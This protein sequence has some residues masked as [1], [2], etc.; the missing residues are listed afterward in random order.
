MKFIKITV[1]IL[2]IISLSGF[3]LT[4]A[5]TS[6]E[7]QKIV[8]EAENL[9]KK[10]LY[11]DAISRLEK[12]IKK[13][14]SCSQAYYLNGKAYHALRNYDVAIKNYKK[15]LE[16]Q[17]GW[18]EACYNI[19]SCY[20]DMG[21]PEQ[22]IKWI[23]QAKGI[24]YGKKE[25]E[26]YKKALEKLINISSGDVKKSYEK[27]LAAGHPPSTPQPSPV[28]KVT[29]KP[30]P[31]PAKPDDMIFIDSGKFTMGS[32]EKDIQSAVN[33]S[34][35]AGW[36]EVER[37]WFTDELPAHEVYVK[38]FYIDKYE[39]TNEKFKKF[40][41][42]TGYKTDAERE[43][44]SVLWEGADWKKVSDAD[45]AHPLGAGSSVKGK[46]DHPVVHVTWNDAKAYATWARMRLPSEAEWEY[47]CSGTDKKIF[48][49]GNKWND[50]YCNNARLNLSYL[51]GFMPDF[52]NGRGTIPVGK[53][54]DGA[55]PFGVMDMSGNVWEWCSDWYSKDYYN[56]SP[57]E[58]PKGPE[59][60]EKKILKGGS[61]YYE[62]PA[63]L[64]A[65]IK[66]A[67]FPGTRNF[68]IGFRCVKD[69]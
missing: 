45:W 58:N 42:S 10:G 62:N 65:S 64:R 11:D 17:A 32:S 14:P 40:V 18:G 6:S 51:V 49:W 30:T 12:A 53:I 29:P 33:M 54:P 44:F 7:V 37:N 35:D 38:G 4:K 39:V 69:K 25:M 24:F 1:F 67:E 2:L 48:P 9:I 27:E 52:F 16:L 13:D 66:L 68:M 43:G 28:A 31:L 26:K 3:Y 63:Y 15:V 19:G 59:K 46:M 47:A 22:A 20:V 41:D 34:K 5:Q 57:S 60:G 50:N 23:A 56:Y 55:S 61:W 8:N 36:T 21:Q